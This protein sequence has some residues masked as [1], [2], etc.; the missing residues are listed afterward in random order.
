M[1]EKR[2]KLSTT[3]ECIGE[4]GCFKFDK[5]DYHEPAVIRNLKIVLP[6]MLHPPSEL[7]A[8]LTSD[9]QFYRATNISIASV[10]FSK[11][12]A[13]TFV[14]QGSVFLQSYIEDISRDDGIIILPSGKLILL[15]DRPTSQTL[16]LEGFHVLTIGK[17]R[18][19]ASV[20]L[21]KTLEPSKG[22]STKVVH[23][24][25]KSLSNIGHLLTE[26]IT[27]TWQPHDDCICPSTIA[28]YFHD[29]GA[30]VEEVGATIILKRRELSPQQIPRLCNFSESTFVF[31]ENDVDFEGLEGWI[32]GMLYE[33]SK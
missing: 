7:K 21:T 17:D 29:S 19:L 2:A 18:I 3:T 31:D 6:S 11:D 16:A 27:F 14:A 1:T 26:P 12:F 4:N 22:I 20:D 32:G 13:K 8:A 28:R 9:T 23:R 25:R 10:I 30:I 33:L 5:N 24:W 15:L